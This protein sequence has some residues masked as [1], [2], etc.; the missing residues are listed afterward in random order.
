MDEKELR[1]IEEYLEDDERWMTLKAIDYGESAIVALVAEVRRLQRE[2]E[3][4]RGT[5]AVY[6]SASDDA[7]F[8]AW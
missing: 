8:D 1:V 7:R 4:A 6:E 3:E 5:I 2:L